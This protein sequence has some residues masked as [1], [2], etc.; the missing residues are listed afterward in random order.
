MNWEAYEEGAALVRERVIEPYDAQNE[1]V[2]PVK[3]EIITR[4]ASTALSP[5]VD[6]PHQEL[7]VSSTLF[8]TSD[9]GA[10]ITQAT[11]VSQALMRVVRDRKLS[12]TMTTGGKSSEYLLVEAWTLMGSMVGVFPVVQWTKP[13]L[14]ANDKTLGWE[15]RVEAKTRDGSIVGAA[16][17]M[18]T[19]DELT[20]KRDGTTFARWGAAD[21]HALRSMAQ[22]RAT[23]KALATALRFIAVLA[24]YAGTPAEEMPRNNAVQ[25]QEPRQGPQ[26]VTAP[27]DFQRSPCPFCRERGWVNNRGNDPVFWLRDKGPHKGSFQCDGRT[28]DGG[29][30]NHLPDLRS[31]EEIHDDSPINF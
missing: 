5:S 23:S 19:R 9:P 10:V 6:S 29:Y 15:A 28:P 4:E 1:D 17:S 7:Q 22:T 25:P 31:G 12:V 8:G 21:E 11:A 24:G 3:A 16:E 2:E 30:A 13:V 27:Q 18:C 14:D 20:K 26:R